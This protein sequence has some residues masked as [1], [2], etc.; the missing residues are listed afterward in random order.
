MVAQRLSEDGFVVLPHDPK[1]L[2]WSVAAHK[3]ALDAVR[4]QGD[5]R[6][7]S[8]WRVGVDELPNAADGSIGGVP[9]RGAW[10][11]LV[12]Q[13]AVWHCAQLSVV[14]PGYP[15]QD[16]LDTDAA[17]GYRLRREAAH[18][19]GL[20][21]EGPQK[22]RHLREPHSFIIGFPLNVASASPLVVWPGSHVI[23][24]QAFASVLAD[25]PTD[26]WGDV[27]VTDVY[28]AA[29]RVVFATCTRIEVPVL[30]GQATLVHRH[31]LHGVAPW[32]T[33]TAPIEGR[34]IAYFRPQLSIIRDWL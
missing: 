11:R 28:Q 17:H 33:G 20:L 22:R 31:L 16:A 7:G 23:M 1:V 21:P 9:L 4:T 8:T 25:V 27:D 26:R 18:V 30:P 14:Y 24:Q 15:Q 10:Q 12:S 5:M 13:P 34:M 32:G 29:R 2:S 19:D 3:A 6:H